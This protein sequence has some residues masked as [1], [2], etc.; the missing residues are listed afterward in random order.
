MENDDSTRK[1]A[2][3]Q[4][5]LGAYYKLRAQKV[6]NS[7]KDFARLCG[8][9]EQTLSAALRGREGYMT[10]KLYEKISTA[11]Q[12]VS[13]NLADSA[14]LE[15]DGDVMGGEAQKNLPDQSETIAGLFKELD[16]KN[17]QIN[18]LLT[19]LENE[20]KKSLCQSSIQ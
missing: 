3:I 8:V 7:Q 6:V 18:R 1:N 14:H 5:I 13:I 10:D 17:A 9:S 16:E 19:L 20:Q 15:I 12:G 11:L 4:E 2:Q